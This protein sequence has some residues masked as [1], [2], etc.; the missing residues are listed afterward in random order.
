MKLKC[1][2]VDDESLARKLIEDNIHQLPFLELIATCKNPFE[3]MQVLQEKEVDLMFLDI[4]MPHI[5]GI[6]LLKSLEKKKQLA[7]YKKQLKLY[8]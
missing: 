4:Q 1:I 6:Q 8:K 7:E 3:A 5:N 2:I